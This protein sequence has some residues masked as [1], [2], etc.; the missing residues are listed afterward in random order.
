MRESEIINIVDD[1]FLV[2][3]PVTEE[4]REFYSGVIK[5]YKE[6]YD[7]DEFK[8]LKSKKLGGYLL[9]MRIDV[10]E[11]ED[12]ETLNDTGQYLYGTGG[13]DGGQEISGSDQEFDKASD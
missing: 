3:F 8:L 1:R 12:I 6:E 7:R 10:V 4:K 11:Y 13:K 5:T 9:G 2:L